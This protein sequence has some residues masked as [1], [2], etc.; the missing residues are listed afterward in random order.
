MVRAGLRS[1]AFVAAPIVACL[2]AACWSSTAPERDASL[3]A[4]DASADG[5]LDAEPDGD[6][7]AES[8]DAVDAAAVETWATTLVVYAPRGYATDFLELPDGGFGLVGYASM[9]EDGLGGSDAWAARLDPH[10]NPLWA[11][12]VGGPGDEWVQAVAPGPDNGMVFAA[13]EYS[14]P[15]GSSVWIARLDGA[16]AITADVLLDGADDEGAWA[17]AP[18]P[19]GGYVIGGSIGRGTR[20][21][22]PWVARIDAD[23]NVAWQRRLPSGIGAVQSLSVAAD[24]DILVAA[25]E[26]TSTSASVWLA[27]L[28]PRGTIRWQRRATGEFGEMGL[29][30][31]MTETT[32][33]DVVAMAGASYR[34]VFV[35]RLDRDGNPR[36]RKMLDASWSFDVMAGDGGEAI[37]GAGRQSPPPFVAPDM[38]LVAL[39]SEGRIVWQTGLDGGYL[40]IA[41]VVRRGRDGS[42]LALSAEIPS[43]LVKLAPNGRFN[44]SCPLIY[45]TSVE[46]T[47]ADVAIDDPG[48]AFEDSTLAPVP[49][50]A[51]PADVP[52][53]VEWR[54]PD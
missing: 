3:D 44:G 50:S 47:D 19:D 38:W 48:F 54:C 7:P 26:R 25:A 49:G 51:A 5:A 16:G 17:V 53:P 8:P 11:E 42:I 20:P 37:L 31:A 43:W 22:D 1:R 35:V 27:R 24:R 46:P 18:L 30:T 34:D 12:F 21:R 36:W 4:A 23:L 29:R 52:C 39:S 45:E 33:G 41:S 6:A 13:I 32:D 9:S 2:A 14:G 15:R 40:E 10:Q 28:D